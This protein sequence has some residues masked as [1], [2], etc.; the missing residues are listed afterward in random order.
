MNTKALYNEI[1]NGAYNEMFAKLYGNTDAA[2]SRA[3]ALC[4]RF[5]ERFGEMEGVALFSA[6]ARTELIGN[7]T[8]HALGKAV[9]AAIDLDI[10]AVA[11]PCKDRLVICGEEG[12]DITLDGEV[13]PEEKGKAAALARGMADSFGGGF[14]AV[15]DSLIPLGMGLSSSAA[16]S[17]LCGKISN[18]FYG[19]GSAD[20]MALSLAA[21]V[22]ENKYF[23]KACGLLD[24]IS[25]SHGGVVCID[26]SSE[27]PVATPVDFNAQP[28][29]IYLVNTGNSHSGKDA[30]YSQI[31]TNMDKAAA[32][33]GKKK[34]GLVPAEEFKKNE[35]LLKSKKSESVY[36]A[37]LHF[38]DENKRVEF[39]CS[40]AALGQTDTCLYAVNGSG[41]SSR[42]NLGN[43]HQE[44][45]EATTELK[46]IAAAVRIHGGGFG[47]AIQCY[48]KPEMKDA[49][50]EKMEALFGEGCVLPVNIRQVGAC[51][52]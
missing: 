6:P 34:L 38:F 37:A 4:E 27:I 12:V 1:K 18:S 32:F 25:C 46:D 20:Y 43:V 52:F 14:Y 47:G 29:G 13:H 41:I 3:L 8:D 22:A 5:E 23:G 19:D 15:T 9:A 44:A 2:I 7:H 33:F 49:F 30:Q 39:F 11:A 45:I 26:F 36:R 17:L 21:R 42:T 48:I 40:R 16:F 51:K 28:Y 24:Q 35:E 31:S 50:Y 10:L